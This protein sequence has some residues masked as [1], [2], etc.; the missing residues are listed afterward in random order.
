MFQ[1]IPGNEQL[2]KKVMDQLQQLILDGE[3]KVGDKLPPERELSAMLNVSRPALKQAISAFN[4]LG[5]IQS[6]QGDGNYVVSN[7]GNMFNPIALAF[8]LENGNEVDVLEFR[9]ILEVKA[10]GLAAL[11]ATPKQVEKLSWIVEGMR[12]VASSEERFE[13]NTRFHSE[14]IRVGGNRLIINIYESLKDLVVKQISTTDGS[15]FYES[16]LAIF[17]AIQKRD[18]AA[19]ART[20]AQHF[21]KKFPNYKYYDQLDKL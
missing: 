18:A 12:F 6:R 9:Y 10:A 11:K 5:I 7:T 20:M 21:T 15:N 13:A 4:M 1:A 17:K 19:A 8:C 14:I 3:L 16:H 2:Y